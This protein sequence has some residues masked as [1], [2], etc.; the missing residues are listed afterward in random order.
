MIKIKRIY[1]SVSVDDG[2]RILVDRIWPRGMSKEKAYIDLWLKEIAPSHELRKWFD[3]DPEKW[4]AFKERYFGELNSNLTVLKQLEKVISEY[5]MI[6]LLYSSKD[7][8]YNQAIA[9]NEY[10]TKCY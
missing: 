2:Y 4:Q 8:T 9:L 3:H 6:T 5:E 10:L 1:E 7:Q